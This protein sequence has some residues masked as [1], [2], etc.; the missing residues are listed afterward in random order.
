MDAKILNYLF[1]DTETTGI[2]NDWNAPITDFDNWPRLVQLAWLL[3]DSNG[4]LILK[5]E[6]IVKP[7][8]FV[9]PKEASNIHG[10]TTEYALTNGDDIS[11]IL[12]QFEEQC[13]KSKYLIAHNIKF[14]S[15]V[16]GSEFLRNFNRNPISKLELICTMEGTT[17]FCKIPGNYGFKWPKLSELH[18]KLFGK[19][20]E[21]AHNALSDVQATAECFWELKRIGQLSGIDSKSLKDFKGE[22]VQRQ[23][24]K[25]SDTDYFQNDFE[26]F[27]IDKKEG[28]IIAI[29]LSGAFQIYDLKTLEKLSEK[30]IIQDIRDDSGPYL[31]EKSEFEKNTFYFLHCHGYR[32]HKYNYITDEVSEFMNPKN[33]SWPEPDPSED[34]TTSYY[35]NLYNF[36]ESTSFSFFKVIDINNILV[37]G[38]TP[39]KTTGEIF[40]L[41]LVDGEHSKIKKQIADFRINGIKKCNDSFIIWSDHEIYKLYYPEYRIEKLKA[42]SDFIIIDICICEIYNRLIVY[43]FS[44]GDYNVRTKYSTILII[45]LNSLSMLKEIHSDNYTGAPY[46]SECQR[47]IGIFSIHNMN[48]SFHKGEHY[49]KITI[50]DTNSLQSIAYLK[51]RQ[52]SENFWIDSPNIIIL[53]DSSLMKFR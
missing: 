18:R 51:D 49:W 46:L 33:P 47:F 42:I 36:P 22:I 16:I 52:Q 24:I 41:C 3:Y 35:Y 25:V 48:P 10:I 27:F 1:F 11:T 28:H 8:G 15:K 53:E 21:G 9:I 26:A 39:N 37:A 13:Q 4:K 17:D 40:F 14:D 31:I 20:F 38:N 2:P 5:N 7:K 30:R 44:K 32:C 50:Y 6:K 12:S 23:E 19:D 29:E 34:F 43:C 45:D